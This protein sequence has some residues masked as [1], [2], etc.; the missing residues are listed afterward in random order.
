M[1]QQLEDLRR[2]RLQ[3]HS[4]APAQGAPTGSHGAPTGQKGSPLSGP[5][6]LEL[7]KLYQELQVNFIITYSP[8][9]N[10]RKHKYKL[11]CASTKWICIRLKC[12][13]F[14]AR[15]RHN[16]EQSSKLAQN[17]ELLN[18]RNAQVTVMDQR[19][20]DLRERLHKKRAEVRN[21]TFFNFN[22]T[23]YSANGNTPNGHFSVDRCCRSNSIYLSSVESYEW[24][25]SVLAADLFPPRRWSLWSGSGCLPLHP[26]SSRGETG[27]GVPHVS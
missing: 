10:V 12:C 7:R 4:V 23:S 21:L 6:A 1:T 22:S 17:K 11:M 5:A 16:L 25:R 18:K 27:G 8:S 9:F 26:G 24:R 2:G 14:Q 19:I 20:G 15:N 3:L 13:V